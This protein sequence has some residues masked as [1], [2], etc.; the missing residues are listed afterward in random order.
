MQ[1]VLITGANGFV[2]SYLT[3]LLISD[4]KVIATGK[5]P[6]RLTIKHP[7]FIYESMDFTNQ[8]E[9]RDIIEKYQPSIIIHSGALSKPDDCEL[10]KEQ[11]Y[12]TNVT[13][14]I[15]LLN[16]AAK[17]KSF[18]ILL[19][20]DFI[21]S[22]IEGMYKEDDEAD[23][24][25][26]YGKTKLEAEALVKAYL[27]GWSII[28]TVLVYGN[29]KTGRNNI[30]TIVANGLRNNQR[31]KIFNDQ[32]R[33]PTYVEDLTNAIKT[34]INK[35]AEGIFHI[36]GEDVYTPYQMAIAVAEYLGLNK[37]LIEEVTEQTF[38][39]PARR[40]LKTGFDVTKA[41]RELNYRPISFNEGL[42]KTFP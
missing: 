3:N 13:G 21:F 25:N 29:P 26:Y 11:A 2:G 15:Y 22:G 14:T 42:R 37:D 19:S 6:S 38:S 24:V 31:L 36:S 12:L 9:V 17:F 32:I 5:G 4:Y 41:K 40:P 39:Q 28:R 1:T 30:L 20:T 16:E 35:K 34:I 7:N 23:P 10:N 27:H 33:T 18:F 8:E